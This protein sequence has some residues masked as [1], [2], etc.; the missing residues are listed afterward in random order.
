MH[1][2]LEKL[3]LKRGIKEIKDLDIE[4]GEKVLYERLNQDLSKKIDLDY[5][6]GFCEKNLKNVQGQMRSLDNSNQKN[7]RLILLQ[8]VYSAILEVIN[9]SPVERINAEKEIED[10]LKLT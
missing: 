8:N 1:R 5:I 3:L 7:E 4:T 2:L 9:S 10:L 6:K